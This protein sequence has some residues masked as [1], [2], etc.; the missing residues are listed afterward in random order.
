[1]DSQDKQDKEYLREVLRERNEEL[2]R[3]LDIKNKSV[4]SDRPE[5]RDRS[6]AR[7]QEPASCHS[8]IW[9]LK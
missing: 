6:P 9:R 5:A 3:L 7:D 8:G 2:S 4:K 1:M